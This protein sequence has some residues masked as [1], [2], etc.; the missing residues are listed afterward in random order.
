MLPGAFSVSIDLEELYET[1]GGMIEMGLQSI[2]QQAAAGAA[3]TAGAGMDVQAAMGV[4]FDGIR[5]FL[6]SAEGL[7][8]ALLEDGE[9][10]AL[11]W[12]YTAFEDSDLDG[13]GGT[14]GL[15]EKLPAAIDPEAQFAL[16]MVADWSELTQRFKPLGDAMFASLPEAKAGFDAYWTSIREAY[17][18]LGDTIVASGGFGEQGM[19]FAFCAEAEQGQAF[20]DKFTAALTSAS[21]LSTPMGVTVGAPQAVEV[22]GLKAQ[23]W[24]LTIDYEQLAQFAGPT[25]APDEA[26]KVHLLR[27]IYGENPK[28]TIAAQGGRVFASFGG[29]PPDLERDVARFAAGPVPAASFLAR[30]HGL[31]SAPRPLLA[32]SIDV[33]RLMAALQ[34]LLAAQG[35]PMEYPDAPLALTAWLGIEGRRWHGGLGARLD[36]VAGMVEAAKQR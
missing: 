18:L 26:A 31:P 3:V 30:L 22:G 10:V 20:V 16:L 5:A 12:V 34:P 32:Y 8:L 36:E 28:L 27:T 7:D 2:E 4:Y 35:T 19:H 17:A 21:S 15:P 14:G 29:G 13:W 9:D 25:L 11:H 23:Q 24:P 33:S 1:W 6:D